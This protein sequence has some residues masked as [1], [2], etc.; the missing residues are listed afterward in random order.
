[1]SCDICEACL[2]S[3]ANVLTRVH[4]CEGLDISS[5]VSVT[6]AALASKEDRPYLRRKTMMSK[7]YKK[8]SQQ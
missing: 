3:N 8:Q 4:L 5:T 2:T 1:M 7:P 6:V